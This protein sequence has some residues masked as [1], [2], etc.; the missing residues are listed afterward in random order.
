MEKRYASN[1]EKKIWWAVKTYT[2]W[3]LHAMAQDYSNERPIK[4]DLHDA[5]NL[6][7]V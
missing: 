6:D 3:R 1:S 7:K 4:A 2:Q 5:K